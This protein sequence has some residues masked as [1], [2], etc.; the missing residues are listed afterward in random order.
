M[1]LRQGDADPGFR[2]GPLIIKIFE[3]AVRPRKFLTEKGWVNF[4]KM[5]FFKKP[6]RLWNF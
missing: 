3:K 1:S 4:Y 6:S 5:S 2:K